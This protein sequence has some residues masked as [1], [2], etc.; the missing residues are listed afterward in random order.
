MLWDTR[1]PSNKSVTAVEAHQAEVNC[2]AFNP[3]N[4]YVLATGSADK[5]V[6]IFDIRNLAHRMHTFQNHTEE[7]FQIGWCTLTLNPKP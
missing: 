7:V 1:S 6:A 5:N 4:E 2:L 3:Y